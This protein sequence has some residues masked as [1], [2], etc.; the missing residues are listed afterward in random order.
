MSAGLLKKI[1]KKN[2]LYKCL[3]KHP[4]NLRL[5]RSYDKL[6]NEINNEIPIQRD[7]YFRNRLIRNMGNSKK[8]WEVVNDI[9]NNSKQFEDPVLRLNNSPI[10]DPFEVANAFNDHFSTITNTI[11]DTTI[12]NSSS[13]QCDSSN[14]SDPFLGQR[15]F[16][17]FFSLY[18]VFSFVLSYIFNLSLKKGVFPDLLKEAIVIPI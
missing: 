12:N 3:K 18:F 8:E 13:C 1:R 7:A 2:A 16:C 15:F 10:S 9:L 6:S 14:S 11:R 17:E 4:N 5:K